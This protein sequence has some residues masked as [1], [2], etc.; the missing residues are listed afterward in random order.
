MTIATGLICNEGIVFG[1]ETD[2][3]IGEMRRRVHKI[4]TR[5]NP[6]AMITGAC[7][8]GHLMDTAIERIFDRFESEQP[9]TTAAVDVALRETMLDL[10]KAEFK[11]YPSKYKTVHLLVAI[12]PSQEKKVE[13][14]SID[15]SSVHRFSKPLEIV[16][17]GDVVQFVADY[18]GSDGLSTDM[19]VV[20]VA[21]IISLAKKVV[22]DVGGDS[23]VHVLTDDGGLQAK[24]FHFYPEEEGLFDFFLSMGRIPLLGMGASSL[25]D[26][27]FEKLLNDFAKNVKWK[28][29]K[30]LKG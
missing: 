2:E 19:G 21:Q 22:R 28:R 9:A 14:W 7:D 20:A 3:A 6:S 15:C 11:V 26:E 5:T 13:A 29:N 12:K 30:I 18:L 17:C 8:N 23:Y 10:Y 27:Q 16:G 24:N 1:A 4:P 25:S